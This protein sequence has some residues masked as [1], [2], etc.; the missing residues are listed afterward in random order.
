MGSTK[1]ELSVAEVG[2]R[3]TQHARRRSAQRGISQLQIDLIRLFGVDHLQKGGGLHCY[4]PD[5]TL[6][7]LRAAL[8][9]CSGVALIK[10]DGDAVVT[11]F[12][13]H[14]KVG[15]TEWAA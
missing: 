10:G 4:I 7:E 11:A 5:R 15:H 3:L 6:S 14:R 13:Q 1:R 8:E 2:G 12:H 9:R